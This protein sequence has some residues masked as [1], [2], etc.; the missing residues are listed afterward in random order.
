MRVKTNYT[1]LFNHQGC[2]LNE[3]IFF[4]INIHCL[5]GM[6]GPPGKSALSL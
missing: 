6:V 1:N 3:T 5:A 4:A 2:R